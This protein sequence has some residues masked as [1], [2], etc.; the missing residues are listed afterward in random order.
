MREKAGKDGRN[1][2]NLIDRH[3]KRERKRKKKERK[4]KKGA[5]GIGR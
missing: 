2:E 3:T 5:G 1:I 4:R